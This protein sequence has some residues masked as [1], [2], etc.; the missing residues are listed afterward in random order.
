MTNPSD[1]PLSPDPPQ[2]PGAP[3]FEDLD[4][5]DI[6]NLIE[7]HRPRDVEDESGPTEPTE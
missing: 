4:G 1:A 3:R 7:A 5:P 2:P 6:A